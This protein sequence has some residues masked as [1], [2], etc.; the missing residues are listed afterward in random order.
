MTDSIDW[1]AELLTRGVIYL[2]SYTDE[3]HSTDDMPAR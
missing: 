3:M 2:S 1:V